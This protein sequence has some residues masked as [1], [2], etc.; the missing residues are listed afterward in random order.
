MILVTLGTQD[1]SFHRLLEAIDKEI[2]KGNIKDEVVVQA[3]LTKYESKNM[4]LIDFLPFDEF[5]KLIKKCDLLITHAGVGSLVTGLKY[6][7]KVIGVPRL[8]KYKEHENDH[9]LQILKSFTKKGY[10]LSVNN[11]NNIGKVLK[12]V[13]NFKPIKYES[14]TTNFVQLIKKH[15]DNDFIK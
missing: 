11:V 12:D 3:G 15:I 14:N 5:D 10:I 2:E 7:K 6:N 9:Q 4:K 13:D 8:K 1:K